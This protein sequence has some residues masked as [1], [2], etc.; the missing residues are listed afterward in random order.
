[1]CTQHECCVTASLP[2]LSAFHSVIPTTLLKGMSADALLKRR[3]DCSKAQRELGVTF[4]D[5]RQS[6]RDMAHFLVH[7]G[8]VAAPSKL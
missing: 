7:A 4:T 5:V 3:Y 1:M 8:V 6:T 2:S